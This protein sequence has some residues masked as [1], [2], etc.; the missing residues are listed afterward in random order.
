MTSSLRLWL[1]YLSLPLSRANVIKWGPFRVSAEFPQSIQLKSCF[2]LFHLQSWCF[3]IRLPRYSLA[4][5]EVCS[6]RGRSG[7]GG[8]R[9]EMLQKGLGSL[10]PSRRR[11]FLST[12]SQVFENHHRLLK[13]HIMSQNINYPET[14]QEIQYVAIAYKRTKQ[15]CITCL[16]YSIRSMYYSMNIGYQCVNNS[17]NGFQCSR[18]LSLCQDMDWGYFFFHFH[19]DHL[20]WFLNKQI[21]LC[22]VQFMV[23]N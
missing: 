7:L 11:R 22:G 10:L 4:L 6:R 1:W 23:P 19:A 15:T 13:N 21:K 3:L 20:T 16:N 17:N 12:A 9:L 5:W 8:S 14:W 2:H 18:Q